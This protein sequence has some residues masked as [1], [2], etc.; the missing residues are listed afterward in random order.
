MNQQ[1]SLRADNPLLPDLAMTE[2]E[3]PRNTLFEKLIS[4]YRIAGRRAEDM[5]IQQMC[6]EVESALKVHFS[7]PIS[8]V[9][10]PSVIHRH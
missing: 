10:S 1:S 5:I 9:T 3:L 2:A 6:G 7:M 8:S 4:R